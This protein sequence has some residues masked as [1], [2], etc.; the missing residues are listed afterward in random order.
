MRAALAD[1]RAANALEPRDADTQAAIVWNLI[2]LRD[3]PALRR[4]LT[5]FAPAAEREPRLWGPFAAA[6]MALNRQAE[7][8]RWFR[9]QAAEQKNDYLWMMAFAE[10]LEANAQPE[11]AW[12][13]RRKVWTDLRQPE[14]LAAIPEEQ[15]LSMR[16]RP[17]GRQPD[18]RRRRPCQGAGRR[19]AAR[20]PQ[21]IAR[22]RAAVTPAGHRRR[23]GGH[24]GR[25]VAATAGVRRGTPVAGELVHA[26]GRRT[27]AT[28]SGRR[29]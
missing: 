26:P 29:Q 20:R 1:W 18:L 24:V 23:T 27:G 28:L 14:V 13:I 19:P 4:A 7:A 22:T 2:A 16:D 25:G 6:H 17:G 8:L 5:L 15:W 21:G 11:V 9:R 12:R 10:C 3:A